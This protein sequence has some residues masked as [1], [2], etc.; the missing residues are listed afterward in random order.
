MQRS[1]CCLLPFETDFL[2][3]LVRNAYLGGVQLETVAQLK[4]SLHKPSS[5]SGR[6]A[7]AHEDICFGPPEGYPNPTL[8]TL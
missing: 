6:P 3:P 4:H 2:L 8:I 7:L 1:V 5:S